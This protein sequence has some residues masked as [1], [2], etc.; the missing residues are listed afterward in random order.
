MQV[1]NPSTQE[2]GGRE[3]KIFLNSS[4]GWCIQQVPR[5]YRPCLKTTTTTRCEFNTS[6]CTQQM[7]D[8]PVLHRKILSENKQETK[9]MAQ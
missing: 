9:K 2:A 5:R 6:Q 8:Q 4:P 3:R 7:P 1:F